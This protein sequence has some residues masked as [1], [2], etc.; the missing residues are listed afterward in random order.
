MIFIQ[1]RI[2]MA[3]RKN[4]S[5]QN[6]RG[7]G[8]N[9]SQKRVKVERIDG[10][11]ETTSLTDVQSANTSRI[12]RQRDS[13]YYFNDGSIVFQVKDTLFKVHSSLLQ[14][15]SKDFEKVFNI[16]P[17]T[18]V[19]L[20]SGGDVGC[21]ENPIIISDLSCRQFRSLM[22]IIYCQP[23]DRIFTTPPTE[24]IDE[25]GA[26]RDFT[27]YVDVARLSR[28]FAMEEIET[29]AKQR[30]ARLAHSA[31]DDIP[32]GFWDP[33]CEGAGTHYQDPLEHTGQERFS[34]VGVEF[35]IVEAIRYAREVSDCSLHY[36]CL[37]LMQYIYDSQDAN[38]KFILSYLRIP[39]LRETDPSLFGYLFLT[40]LNAGSSVFSSAS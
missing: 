18:S 40:I 27:F 14:L 7:P 12:H 4:T 2:T 24:Y 5:G 1:S 20:E 30:L 32:N 33:I 17:N 39:N 28:R 22:K 13:D 23:T 35:P 10:Q 26:A 31:S 11:A 29:W 34:Y 36:D 8:P 16:P 21:D 19:S 6:S 25:K 37:N 38:I 3:K 15:R 9:S